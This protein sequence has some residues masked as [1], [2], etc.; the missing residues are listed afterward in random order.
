MAKRISA[1]LRVDH[2]A[3]EA[4]GAYDRFLDIDSLL[5]V[6]PHL[7]AES[8]TAEMQEAARSLDAFWSDT[9][10]I[11]RH[12]RE[13]GDPFW[14]AAC[15]RFTFPEN[16]NVGLGYA[17]GSTAGAAVGPE[18]A[19]KLVET[20]AAIVQAG[21]TDPK[22]FELVG[23]L[24]PNIGPD[25]ISDVTVHIIQRQLLEFTQRVCRDL[26][27]P[28]RSFTIDG[29][30][31]WLPS[32]PKTH[33]HIVLL[34]RDVLRKLPVAF[35]WTDVDLVCRYNDEL[36]GRVNNMI[37]ANWKR[38]VADNKKAKLKDVLIENPGVLRDL[39]QQYREKRAMPYDFNEDELGETL[40]YEA[41]AAIVEKFPL[42]LRGLGP[43]TPDNMMPVVRQICDHFRRLVENNGLCRVFWTDTGKL[44]HERLAQLL[45][46]GVAD[47]YCRANDLDLTPEA[48]SGRGPVD[49]KMSRGYE[50]RVLVEVK[51]ST[52]RKLLHGFKTQIETYAKAEQTDQKIYLII[53]VDGA[54][55]K[56]KD[57]EA[58]QSA[59]IRDGKPAPEIKIV[60]GRMKDS[61]SHLDEAA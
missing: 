11:L 48:N 2:A 50:K 5:H 34:P 42:D 20:G 25:R 21:V 17:K 26:H 61:A 40:W 13:K 10:S 56:I 14:K 37:G 52:N 57:V 38:A 1:V 8:A 47:A 49:F 54:T 46:F 36:R 15:R 51:W 3:L 28:T 16:R 39:I 18:L 7:L 55:T 12:V 35:C 9:V 45:F 23:V 4:A 33:A 31:Y 58:A 6:D 27:A 44:R 30:T 59:A 22:V 60:D 41:A 29:A 32:H 24:E 19:A 53:R 43:V